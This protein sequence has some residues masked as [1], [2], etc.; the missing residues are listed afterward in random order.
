MTMVMICVWQGEGW[1]YRVPE[2]AW[3]DMPGR[4]DINP[5][6]TACVADGATVS[7]EPEEDEAESVGEAPA[8]KRCVDAATQ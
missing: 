2:P 7:A 3:A 8:K 5:T 1:C 6:V 4:I